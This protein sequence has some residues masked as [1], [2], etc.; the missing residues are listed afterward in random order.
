LHDV[1]C[2]L[3]LQ[4]EDDNVMR[5]GFLVALVLAFGLAAAGTATAQERATLLLKSGERV[6]GQLVD[7][8][9]SD[10]TIRVSGDDRRIPIRDVAVVDF[11]GSAQNL[12]AAELNRV[13][14][15]R[16]VL[17]TRGGEV[18]EGKLYD[19]GGR[20]PLRITFTTS[21]QERDFSSN[22][23]G[24]IYLARPGNT[25]TGT[26]G[27]PAGGEGSRTIQV[28][29]NRAWTATGI[30]VRKGEVV[31]FSSRGEVRLGGTTDDTS[32]VNGRQGA[33]APRSSAPR[34]FLGGLIGRVGNGDPFG[35]GGQTSVPMPNDGQLYLG[36]N[37]SSFQDNA[38]EY[39]V[40]VT[41]AGGPT[42]VR[43]VPR[44]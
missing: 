6:S 32:G 16:N 41:A 7:M 31:Q 42:G 34:V 36:V 26:G 11:T 12:P 21:G 5:K 10:F 33:Y 24:R 44:R 3:T 37:D 18:V 13:S 40:V 19:V 23:V 39:T 2:V 29:A 17:V 28:P 22:D 4:R 25:A 1:F 14:G 9:G 15:G 30:T 20:R 38:G 43:A 35:I 27:T 8:G